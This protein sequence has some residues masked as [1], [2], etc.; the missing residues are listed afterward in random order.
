MT[1]R[2]RELIDAGRSPESIAEELTRKLDR[3]ISVE[4]VK[5]A[6]QPA[7]SVPKSW[8]AALGLEAGAA[9]APVD[10][11]PTWG[12]GDDGPAGPDPAAGGEGRR[13]EQPPK[14]PDDAKLAPVPALITATAQKRI[15]ELHV[16]AG[17]AVAVAVDPQ[18]FETDTGPGG[19]I[20]AIWKDKADPIA[21]AWVRWAQEGNKFAASF[22]R[23]MSTGGAGGELLLGY[24]A[25]LG[26]T[27]YI[28][29]QMPDNEATRAVYGRYTK[30][31]RP[32]PVPGSRPDE[33]PAGDGDGAPASGSADSLGAAAGAAR[34]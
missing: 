32:D 11:P 14:K 22:V 9:S 20:G 26:G 25:L 19:G 24:A 30:Y 4:R 23:L 7:R 13:Q 31:R 16:F 12:S 15:A 18:G 6:A 27:A 34:G 10:P 5:G 8:A 2:L 21:E 3:R 28:I 17:A 29:G 1:N 33:R